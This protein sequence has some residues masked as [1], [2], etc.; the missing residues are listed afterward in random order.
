M[1]RSIWRPSMRSGSVAPPSRR[2]PVMPLISFT[3]HQSPH[4]PFSSLL[5]PFS[6]TS[7]SPILVPGLEHESTSARKI[8]V[9]LRCP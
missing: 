9:W 2:R 4:T 7:C 6:R 1:P 5:K 8:L 3:P